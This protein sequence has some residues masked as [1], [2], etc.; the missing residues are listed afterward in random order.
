MERVSGNI[1]YSPSGL[2]FSGS[3]FLYIAGYLIHLGWPVCNHL[4]AEQA[5]CQCRFGQERVLFGQDAVW[6]LEI[7]PIGD[8]LET[9]R[10]GRVKCFLQY[11]TGIGI[12]LSAT[13]IKRTRRP[14]DIIDIEQSI[15]KAQPIDKARP[16]G[17]EQSK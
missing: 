1:T 10:H 13:E 6:S 12:L 9:F 4:H 2:F 5:V 15:D 14:S 3:G 11:K 16:V 17:K 7:E 8:T